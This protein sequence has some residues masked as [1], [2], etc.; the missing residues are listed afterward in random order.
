MDTREDMIAHLERIGFMAPD[1]KMC[2]EWYYHAPD[3]TSVF[4]PRHK[5]SA[6]CQSGKHA[7]CTCDTC[8]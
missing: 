4:A 2:Q 8:F 7:H 5:A 6:G 1:C 3:P